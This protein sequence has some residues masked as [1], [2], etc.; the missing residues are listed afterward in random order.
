MGSRSF[1]PTDCLTIAGYREQAIL[2]CG[3]KGPRVTEP[4][5]R[6]RGDELCEYLLE[7]S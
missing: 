6:A 2:M 7:W 5:C 3:G 4:R 1:S